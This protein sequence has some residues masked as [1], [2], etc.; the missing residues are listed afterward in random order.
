MKDKG[1]FDIFFVF[2]I[3]LFIIQSNNYNPETH[4]YNQDFAKIDSFALISD[5]VVV[6][7]LADQT[8]SN[9]CTLD[10]VNNYKT[11]LESYFS[12]FKNQINNNS[13]ENITFRVE[14][15]TLNSGILTGEI[16][17]EY[18]YNTSIFSKNISKT[19]KYSK[20]IQANSSAACNIKI[21]DKYD[22]DYQQ[23]NITD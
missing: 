2:I 3:F 18:N 5:Q 21:I 19:F 11:K 4:N 14:T 7:A 10:N 20:E 1:F 17:L 13:A 22:H 23:L 6:D 8:Y 9:S 12:D 16:V 15:P